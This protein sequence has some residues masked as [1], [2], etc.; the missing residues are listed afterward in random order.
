MAK[1]LN[2]VMLIGNLGKDPEVRHLQDGTS[3]ANFPLATSESYKRKDTGEVITNTDWHNIVVWRGLADIAEKYIKKGDKI[4][5]EGRLRT[6]SYQNDKGETRY[7][8]EVVA[9]ELLMLTPP[10]QQ[11]Q[12]PQVS[13]PQA[14]PPP[15]DEE[16]DDLPF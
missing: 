9:D 15:L 8:T 3:V 11:R 16:D 6:R 4:Y 5:V 12:Q 13:T 2:K 7:I 14:P 1:S 10:A